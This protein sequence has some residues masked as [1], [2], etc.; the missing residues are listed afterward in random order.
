MT[1]C[2]LVHIKYVFMCSCVS[3]SEVVASVYY[4]SL[5]FSSKKLYKHHITG[6]IV[7]AVIYS[8]MSCEN[9]KYHHA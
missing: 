8:L 2:H 5:H 7:P 4:A 3:N 6:A 1:S 9:L